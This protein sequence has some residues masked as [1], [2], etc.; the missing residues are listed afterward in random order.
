MPLAQ[1]FSVGA[2]GIASMNQPKGLYSI[3]VYPGML[4]DIEFGQ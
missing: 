4:L 3:Q 2:G 1:T